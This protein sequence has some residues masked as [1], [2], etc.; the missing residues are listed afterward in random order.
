MAELENTE[1][2][3]GTQTRLRCRLPGLSGLGKG[4]GNHAIFILLVSGPV[5]Q[6]P[7]RSFICL[8]MH[9]S[10]FVTVFLL[11]FL[12]WRCVYGGLLSA[13]GLRGQ[14]ESQINGH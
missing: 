1:A 10:N 7:S 3:V 14:V 5:A 8:R 6:S 2:Y 11:W 4:P 9:L 12:V 13:A